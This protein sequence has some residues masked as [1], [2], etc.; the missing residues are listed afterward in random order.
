M[1]SSNQAFL[2]HPRGIFYRPQKY[3]SNNVL[4][5]LIRDHLTPALTRFVVGNQIPN[6]IFDPSFDHNSC[7]S[8]L[9]EGCEGTSNIYNSRLFNGIL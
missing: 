9:N 5:I 3:L 6:L 8:S 1:S 2:G 7:I 4:H